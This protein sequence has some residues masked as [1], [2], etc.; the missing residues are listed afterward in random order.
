MVDVDEDAGDTAQEEGEQYAMA[1]VT[2]FNERMEKAAEPGAQGLYRLQSG[3]EP[4][5]Y[6]PCYQ[7]QKQSG[8]GGR[9]EKY[10]RGINLMIKK[11]YGDIYESSFR[12]I[13]PYH[14]LLYKSSRI[15]P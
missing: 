3:E 6:G 5:V 8:Q 12:M 7:D 11:M 1:S 10:G 9:N 14:G 13:N 4:S 2:V 15:R